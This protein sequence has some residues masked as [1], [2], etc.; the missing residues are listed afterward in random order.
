[1]A[2][3]NFTSTNDRIESVKI[4]DVLGKNVMTVS[5][6]SNNVSVD[7]SSLTKG[8]YFAKIA[9]AKATETIKLMKN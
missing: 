1:M 7:G 2:Y 9:T 6:K 5:P 8:I 3:W 4:V